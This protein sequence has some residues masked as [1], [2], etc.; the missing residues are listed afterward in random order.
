[1]YTKFSFSEA[2]VIESLKEVGVEMIPQSDE[3]IV[4]MI[5]PEGSIHLLDDS[6]T[7]F[8]E[9]SNDMVVPYNVNNRTEANVSSIAVISL[10]IHTQNKP[11]YHEASLTNCATCPAA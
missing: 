8:D 7:F 11:S 3:G 6:F 2:D 5:T 10:N 9:K 4:R 1:M